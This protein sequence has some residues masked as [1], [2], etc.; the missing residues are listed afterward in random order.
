MEQEIK[1]FDL[2]D[3]SFWL[4][5]ILVAG[6]LIYI[7]GQMSYQSQMLAQQ[8]G[9]Q[10]SVSGEGKVYAK[11]DVAIVNLGVMTQ[12]ASVAAV[13]SDNTT[14]MNAIIAAMKKLNIADKDIQTTEYD[15]SPQYNYTQEKGQ[16][17]TGYTLTQNVQVKIRDFTQISNV[18]SGATSQGANQVGDLQFTVDNPDQA[19]N[20]AEASAIAEAKGNAKSLETSS[21]IQLGK[22][23]NVSVGNSSPG[24]VMYNA[25]GAGVA[26][27]A[28]APVIQP[29]QQEIDVTVTLT[30]QV[31]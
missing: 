16:V 23:I 11:P 30:Y 29:G 8:N 10:I 5:G 4:A 19:K 7:V 18:L 12:G 22:L 2:A 6:V 27:S 20:Q 17:F 31:K 14:K 25:M 28:V 1:K 3:R 21:G 15:L 26:E 9:N 24:P 13:T